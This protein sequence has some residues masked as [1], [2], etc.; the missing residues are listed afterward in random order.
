[1]TLNVREICAQA[2]EDMRAGACRI[3]ASQPRDHCQTWQR[4]ISE[5]LGQHERYTIV[6]MRSFRALAGPL[7]VEGVERW[8]LTSGQG[9]IGVRVVDRLVLVERCQDQGEP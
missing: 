2:L 4:R 8:W 7:S 3:G 1:V 6:N 9:W 5:H